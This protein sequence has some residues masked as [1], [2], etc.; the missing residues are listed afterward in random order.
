MTYLTVGV[1][2]SGF[3]ARQHLRSWMTSGARI[4]I[5]SQDLM[6]AERLATEHGGRAVG[7]LRE[8]LD[9]CD[10]AD[11]C[12]PTDQHL[13]VVAEAASARVDVIC[14]KP[15]ARTTREARQ[16]VALCENAGVKLFPAHVVRFIPQ[17]EAAYKEVR[18]GS[19]GELAVMHLYRSGP[20]PTWSKWF[21]DVS[22]SGG[23]LMDFLIHDY[24][25]ALWLAGPVR[26][27]FARS[28]RGEGEDGKE[29]G[30]VVL[31]HES[32]AIS[33]VEGTWTAGNQP[34]TSSF[35]L[36]GDRGYLVSGTYP[37]QDIHWRDDS[38]ATRRLVVSPGL[39]GSTPF[40]RE[41]ANFAAAAA[42]TASAAVEPVDGLLAVQVAEAAIESAKLKVAVDVEGE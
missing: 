16:I 11:V 5:F 31:T 41:L 39:V 12:T 23:L 32:G 19:L 40:D 6:E 24:D 30:I 34:L 15:L 14:E 7:T 13:D 33:H 2:G 35:R 20:R 36:Y 17:Y 21:S 26:R 10:I 22:R 29:I 25:I 4:I 38:G 42:G 18:Q 1:I 9:E 8:L 3:I 28:V 37:G 27:V